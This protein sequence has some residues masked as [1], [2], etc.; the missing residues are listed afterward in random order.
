MLD[1]NRNLGMPYFHNGEGLKLNDMLKKGIYRTILITTILVL[2]LLVALQLVAKA[3]MTNFLDR[4][5]PSHIQLE[6][7]G[8][9]VNVFTGT[10]G[11]DGVNM[12]WSD[13]DTT[14]VHSILKMEALNL[15]GFG[16]LD[17]L[18]R[19][20]LSLEQL[21]M[22]KPKMK[23]M[24]YRHF[25]QKDTLKAKGSGI[26]RELAIARF[27]I[28]E[29]EFTQLQEGPDS[30][31]FQVD[32]LDV[33]IRDLK[34]NGVTI[35]NKIPFSYG[36]YAFGTG[37]VLVDLGP[38]EI[39][40]FNSMD[41]SEGDMLL[42]ELTLTSK[43]SRRELSKILEHE[44]DYIDLKIPRIGLSGLDFG[45]DGNRFFLNIASGILNAPVLEM[46]RD[47]LIAD[48]LKKKKLYGQM[49]R[50]LPFD[51]DIAVLDIQK[52]Y[53]AYAELVAEGT[54]PGGI[55][56]SDIDT[57]LKTIS[58]TDRGEGGTKIE[59]RAKLMGEAP[60]LL[61]WNF[62]PAKEN[63]AF[64]ISG[65]VANFRAESI[66]PFLKSNL[67]AEAEGEVKELY[68]TIHGDALSAKGDMKMHYGDFTFKVLQKD[69]KGVNKLLTAIGNIFVNDGSK[70]DGK[71]YRYGEI[72][73][74]RDD[75]K[76]FFN[77]L[78]LNVR[79][80][81]LSTLTGDGKKKNV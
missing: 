64:L 10:V 52:G 36:D 73:A 47:K 43:H 29:G 11:L 44:R 1:F 12:E 25:S 17:F 74:E 51:L 15:E 45:S 2:V 24:P 81:I 68:F 66:N 71:G 35:K 48:D 59:I 32:K 55:F 42:K 19:N 54:D 4:N 50:E 37:K 60:L 31:K 80:G 38:F 79:A 22:V 41:I 33:S 26:K 40:E 72:Y 21:A 27:I 30:I 34:T 78:W 7:S 49:L 57:G 16:Y 65:S 46:Y 18:F 5:I 3:I 67:R 39:M 77:Y 8:S 6:Y 76:S 28:V 69:R 63:D 70:T 56:F 13:P 53:I 58:N 61:N 23:Y 62:D 9:R 20:T 14:G 75:T